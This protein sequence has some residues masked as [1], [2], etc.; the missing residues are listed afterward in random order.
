MNIVEST[1]I[2]VGVIMTAVI[3]L[4]IFLVIF[5]KYLFGSTEIS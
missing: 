4:L 5:G 2:I 3:I 1:E